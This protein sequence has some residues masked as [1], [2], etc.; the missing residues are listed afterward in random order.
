MHWKNTH[1]VLYKTKKI[2]FEKWRIKQNMQS[3]SK[4]KQKNSKKKKKFFFP[5]SSVLTNPNQQVN[6]KIRGKKKKE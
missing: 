5:I 4:T 2:N 1:W 3:K 6:K